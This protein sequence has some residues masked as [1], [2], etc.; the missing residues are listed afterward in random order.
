[1]SID[2]S[3]SLAERI[4]AWVKQERPI[5]GVAVLDDIQLS[6]NEWLALEGEWAGVELI[7]GKA[8][9]SPSPSDDHQFVS[10]KTFSRLDRFVEERELGIIYSAPLDVLVAPNTV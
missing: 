8:Q 2:T 6:A 10:G 3:L 1:M 7:E 5:E 4:D 9:M